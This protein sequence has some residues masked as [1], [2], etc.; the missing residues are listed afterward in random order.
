MTI[1]PEK[2]RELGTK[3]LHIGHVAAPK[4]FIVKEGDLAEFSQA[5]RQA[6]DEIERLRDGYTHQEIADMTRK[7][8]SGSRTFNASGD[9]A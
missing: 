6:A 9:G 1:T 4:L 3:A 7:L 2:L 5:L 8:F